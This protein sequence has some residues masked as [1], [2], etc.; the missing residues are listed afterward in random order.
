MPQTEILLWTTPEGPPEALQASECGELLDF[1][2]ASCLILAQRQP[3]KFAR[4]SGERPVIS[5]GL[6]KIETHF[7]P[8]VGPKPCQKLQEQTQSELDGN[9][10]SFQLATSTPPQSVIDRTIAPSARM[11]TFRFPT[12]LYGVYQT[13]GY[14]TG[15]KL[16]GTNCSIA[17]NCSVALARPNHGNL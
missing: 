5:S 15:P 12:P 14:I 8:A 4:P 7:T 6:K 17:K 13:R 3:G 2:R 1:A 16:A 9:W 10:S 11:T